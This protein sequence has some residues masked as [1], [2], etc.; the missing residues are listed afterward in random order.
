MLSSTL[1]CTLL[2]GD[3]CNIVHLAMIYSHWRQRKVPESQQITVYSTILMGIHLASTFLVATY[4]KVAI[5]ILVHGLHLVWV[6]AASLCASSFRLIS[7]MCSSL[8]APPRLLPS[9]NFHKLLQWPP[10]LFFL[11]LHSYLKNFFCFCNWYCF[12]YL[13]KLFIWRQ[14]I[15]ERRDRESIQQPVLGKPVRNPI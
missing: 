11:P 15:Q 5:N 9:L 3:P 12:S 1:H 4:K 8:S 7:G 6:P 13:K 14:N 10:S 2:E